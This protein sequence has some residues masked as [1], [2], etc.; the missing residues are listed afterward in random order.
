[1]RPLNPSGG[2]CLV[3]LT[4][5]RTLGGLESSAR[6]ALDVLALAEA[7]RLL[8]AIVGRPRLE[9]DPSAGPEL[10][11]LCGHLPLALRIAGNRLASR[12]QWT[13]RQLVSLLDDQQRRLAA[14]TAGDLG[15]EAAFAVSYRQL[16]PAA[17]A[18]FR[19]AALVPGPRFSVR[20]AA[21]ALVHPLTTSWCSSSRPPA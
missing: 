12:P 11:R 18:I 15:V 10:A 9:A 21:R 3:L 5:R 4:S 20:L 19:Y 16:S 1:V 17:A 13:I 8:A 7:V 6:I 2:R 14:L